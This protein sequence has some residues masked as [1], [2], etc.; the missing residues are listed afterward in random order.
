[1]E[2]REK[3]ARFKTEREASK[4]AISIAAKG[5]NTPANGSI[6]GV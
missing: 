1:M 3:L 5:A 2:L 6:D 4:N